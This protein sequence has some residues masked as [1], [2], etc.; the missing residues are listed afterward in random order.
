MAEQATLEGFNAAALRVGVTGAMRTAPLGTEVQKDFSKKY[1]TETYLNRGYLSP[2]GVAIEFD[3]DTNELIPWQEMV[4]IRRDITKSVKTIQV[5]LW[6][7]TKENAELYFGVPGGT[8]VVNED[9]S[10]YLDEEG[11]PE[12][13]HQQVVLDVVDGNKAMK[14]TMLD[15][16]VTERSGMTIKRDEAI[17]LQVTLSGYPAGVEYAE[18]GLEG[19]TNRWIF[20]ASWDGSGATGPVTGGGDNPTDPG[21]DNGSGDGDDNG[22]AEGNE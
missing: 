4:A 13:E 19:V 12:F 5:T 9:G 3:E 6:Q 21:D 18:Q 22:S 15:A 17:G 8:I 1:D 2:D 20:S 14:L 10:W 16:Q 11:V 7:F